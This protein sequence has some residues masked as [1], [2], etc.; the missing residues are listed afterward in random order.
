MAF[1]TPTRESVGT[2]AFLRLPFVQQRPQR[3][4]QGPASNFQGVRTV[5]VDHLIGLRRSFRHV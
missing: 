2:F 3:A 5:G 4:K 1:T